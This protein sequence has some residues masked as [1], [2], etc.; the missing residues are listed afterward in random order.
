MHLLSATLVRPVAGRTYRV[1]EMQGRRFESGPSSDGSSA[2]ER[3]FAPRGASSVPNLS[4][5]PV[6]CGRKMMV[7]TPWTFEVV[8]LDGV[9]RVQPVD[10]GRKFGLSGRHFIW[11]ESGRRVLGCVAV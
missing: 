10:A 9:C 4:A 5:T 3:G 6:R 7:L 1:F 11:F 8:N 2:V